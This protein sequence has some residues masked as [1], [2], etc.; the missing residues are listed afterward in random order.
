MPND[1]PIAVVGLSYRAPSIGRKGLWEYLAH[2][3]SALT[4]IPA[5]RFDKSAY[6]RP[7]PDKSGVFRAEGAHFVPGDIYAFDAAFFNMR[8]EEARHSDPQ[9]RLMLERA[10]E[11]A[12]DAGHSLVDLAGQKIGVFIGCGQQE[13][14][15]RHGDDLYS[16]KTFSATGTAPCMVANRISYFFD[17]DGPSVAVDAACASSVYAAHQAVSALRNG[18]CNAAFVGAAALTLG[19]GGWLALEKTGSFSYDEKASGFG[20]G[21]GAACLLIK[22]IDDAIRDG[23]PVHA[24]I[25]SSA[26]NHGGRSEGITMPNEE[27][28]RKLLL[29]VHESVG[30][31]PSETPVVEDFYLFARP[32]LTRLYRHLEGASGILGM[33]KAILMV[34][35]GIILPT[36]GFENI[37]PRIEGKE[38]IKVPETAIPWPASEPRRVIVTNFGNAGFGGS[39][40]AIILEQALSTSVANGTNGMDDANGINGING[41]KSHGVAT[42]I[43]RLFV[44]SAKTEKSLLSYMSSFDEYLDEAPES[45]DFVKNLSY[46]LGGRRT[47][48][49]YRVAVIADSMASLQEKLSIAKPS[50]IKDRVLVFAFT[51]QGAQ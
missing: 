49:P 5:E 28:H 23:D 1:T 30:L 14:S 24:V 13:Y 21:E 36:A 25:R 12:E 3:R 34:K 26:C 51:G 41:M 20:R 16:A 37:N 10:L 48:Y 22:R 44:L 42:P 18:E 50:R 4:E 29:A 45:N 46:T 17:I 9:H 19:P 40:S 39:N 38:K 15:Q 2:A 47:H 8:A 35:K 33:V 31:S 32:I 11:A 43:Q 27:A 6:W 7:G